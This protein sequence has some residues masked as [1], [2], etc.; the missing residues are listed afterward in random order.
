MAA[1]EGGRARRREMPM[2][3]PQ[4]SASCAA[5]A[6]GSATRAA[7]SGGRCPSAFGGPQSTA[8]APAPSGLAPPSKVRRRTGVRTECRTILGA[9]GVVIRQPRGRAREAMRRAWVRP[10]LAHAVTCQCAVA[11]APDAMLGGGKRHCAGHSAGTWKSPR[12]S[13]ERT[14]T[15][16]P[17]G[18]GT[19]V[20]SSLTRGSE[21][22]C[23]RACRRGPETSARRR[24]RTGRQ[25]GGHRRVHTSVRSRGAA[26]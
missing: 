22:G 10:Q 18:A 26:R 8:A 23:G 15:V 20:T 25:H 2:R 6:P 3:R 24:H 14:R 1:G 4:A 11:G 19:R 7:A 9:A 17:A 16:A 13:P 12:A 21:G 5:A